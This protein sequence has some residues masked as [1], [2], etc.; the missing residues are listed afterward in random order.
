M[1]VALTACGSPFRDRTATPIHGTLTV[2]DLSTPRPTP[3]A[4]R[5][6]LGDSL[7]IRFYRNPELNN[8]VI[9]RPDGMISL[10]LI[11]DVPAAGSS[12]QDLG[13]EL[14]HRYAR[15]LAVPDVTVIVTR[16]GGQRVWIG[17]E[18]GVQGELELVPGLTMLG[19]IQKAGG[20]KNT[21]RLEQV[22]LI[23]KATDGRPR[24]AS[25][26][27]TDVQ[28]GTHPERDIQ[29]EPYDIV[30]VPRSAVGNVNTFMELYITRNIPAGGVWL[31]FLA[32]AGL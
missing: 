8:D 24:G 27:L 4:Y 19:A 20:F 23:R 9:V 17:G 18:V 32:A 14:E 7:A 21:A 10:P 31:N 28:R 1:M 5:I 13:H 25:F 6:Q 11:N 29:L 12:P 26:D 22:V 3:L 30:V 2:Q 16:F 15:E